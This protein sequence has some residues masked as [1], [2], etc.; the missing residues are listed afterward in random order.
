MEYLPAYD[1]RSLSVAFSDVAAQSLAAGEY[2][3]WD[4][5]NEAYGLAALQRGDI[6]GSTWVLLKLDGIYNIPLLA[7]LYARLPG[8]SKAEADRLLGDGS[9]ICASRAAGRYEYVIDRAGGDCPGGCTEHEAHRFS[10]ESSG[11]IDVLDV[12]SSES[13]EPAPA[14]FGALCR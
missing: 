3:A 10:S 9:T 14:W 11:Q 2:T 6:Y 5:L 13:A 8:V 7:E 12:W 4:C 1:G